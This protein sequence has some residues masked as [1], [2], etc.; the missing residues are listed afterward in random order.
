MK[1]LIV[2]YSRSG[3]TK[4]VA[5]FIGKKI[6]ATVEELIDKDKREGVLGYIRSGKEAMKKELAEIEAIKNNPEDFDLIFIG[7]PVWAGTMAPAV[8]TYI[9]KNKDKIKKAIFFSTQGGTREQKV[10][11]EMEAV[12]GKS[13][14]EYFYLTTGEIKRGDFES[15]VLEALKGMD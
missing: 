14:E 8:R 1:T 13:P 12:F 15:K 5:E 9:E 10:F 7:T 2:Y 4:K 3:V 6:G 11:H